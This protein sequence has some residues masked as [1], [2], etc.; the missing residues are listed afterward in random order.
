MSNS[1]DKTMTGVS[2]R[3]ILK[4]AGAVAG[5]AA[6]SGAITGFPAVW[7]QEPKVLRYLGTAVNQ[8]DEISKKVKEDLGITI[9]YISATTDDVVKRVVTQPNSFDVLDTEYWSLKKLVPSGNILGMDAK[10]I[11]EFNNITPIFTKGEL[12]NGKKIG[13]QGTAPKKVMFVEGANSTKFA[14]GVTDF[15]TKGFEAHPI[16]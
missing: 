7:S 14:T 3:G 11:K 10:R 4:G 2:R 9:E 12:P 6:G 16:L 1:R 13:D 8:G 15:E 5:A